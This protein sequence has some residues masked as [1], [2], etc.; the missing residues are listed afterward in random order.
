MTKQQF[1][2]LLTNINKVPCPITFILNRQNSKVMFDMLYLANL[3]N[4]NIVV[5]TPI[6]QDSYKSG[7]LI[8]FSRVYEKGEGDTIIAELDFASAYPSEALLLMEMVPKLR[9]YLQF[10]LSTWQAKFDEKDPLKKLNLKLVLN[11]FYGSLG[12]SKKQTQFLVR[13]N[14]AAAKKICSGLR[15]LMEATTEFFSKF[16]EVL[17]GH[18]DSIFVK[19][20]R[21]AIVEGVTNWN[22]DIRKNKKYVKLELKCTIEK[23]V[24]FNETS[25]CGIFVDKDGKRKLMKTGMLFN[26]I[27][28]PTLY[29]NMIDEIFFTALDKST[30]LEEFKTLYF[31]RAAEV[32]F[33]LLFTQFTNLQTR[34]SR[35]QKR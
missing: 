8:K 12:I 29:R 24:I 23:L 11:K 15:A 33:E 16:C 19:G 35:T 18:T 2:G 32:R 21:A 4:T 31:E 20:N 27:T 13:S 17:F 10:Y 9:P 30:T 3:R 7:A 28:I 1:Y 22:R 5:D 34:R 25:K 14:I 26:S 6:D